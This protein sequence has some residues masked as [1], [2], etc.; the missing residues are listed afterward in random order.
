M[1][2]EKELLNDEGKDGVD[3]KEKDGAEFDNSKDDAK[4]DKTDDG[5][6]ESKKVEDGKDDQAK[7]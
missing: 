1:N 4:K 5:T 2:P 7:D 3:S 6:D